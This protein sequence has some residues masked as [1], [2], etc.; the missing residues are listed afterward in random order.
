MIAGASFHLAA[1]SENFHSDFPRMYHTAI[2]ARKIQLAMEEL[3]P[4]PNVPIP[5]LTMHT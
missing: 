3:S 5:R 4:R 2:T 1:R